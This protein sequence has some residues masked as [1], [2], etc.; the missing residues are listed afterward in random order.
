MKSK[1]IAEAE[2]QKTFLVVL[3]AGEEAFSALTDFVQREGIG[4]ASLTRW[5]PSSARRS[6]GSTA[7]RTSM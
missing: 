7:R 6:P 1:M 5:A 2:G 4:A 3:A